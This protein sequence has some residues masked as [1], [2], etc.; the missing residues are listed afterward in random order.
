MNRKTTLKLVFVCIVLILVLVILYSG[1]Q[2]LE[3]TVFA[4]AQAQPQMQTQSRTIVRDGVKYYPRQ[5]I[6]VLMLMGINRS[7]A[8]RPVEFNHGG[9]VD[10]VALVVFDSVKKEYNILPINRDLM[11][12]MPALNEFG[13]EV[14][15]YNGQLAFAHTFGDGMESSC[16]NVR[17]TVSNLLYGVDIDYYFAMNMETI[18][19]LNDAVG[20][21]TVTIRDD[22]SAVDATLTPGQLKL[23]GEQAVRFVQSRFGVGDQLNLSRMERQEEYMRNFV[24]ALKQALDR[25][26][27]FVEKTYSKIAD[28]TVT[29]CSVQILS[30]LEQDYGDYPMGRFC[31]IEGENVLGEEFYEFHPD[32]EALDALIL[33]LFYAP[34]A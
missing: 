21:V 24:T 8:V 2:I 29:D 26:S 23:S 18:G 12:D 31:S 3:S 32:E 9:A 25:E 6:T 20:G 22:F 28:Y 7:G 13:K 10:M 34:K 5:D 14:G 30:R 19:I 33:E 1:F 16:E 11:V 15:V 27:G 4:P 17:K